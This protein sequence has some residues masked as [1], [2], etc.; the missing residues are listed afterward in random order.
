MTDYNLL[1]IIFLADVLS[2]LM[3]FL[4]I[5]NDNQNLLKLIIFLKINQS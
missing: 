5:L 1:K 3:I 4:F 2:Y